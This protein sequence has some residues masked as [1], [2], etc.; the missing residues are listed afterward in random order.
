MVL[1]ATFLNCYSQV[2]PCATDF[3]HND[4][5]KNSSFYRS[6]FE[7]NESR[8]NSFIHSQKNLRVSTSSEVLYTIP[9]VVHVLEPDTSASIMTDQEIEEMISRL[10]NQLRAGEG[11][12]DSQDINI[13]FALA[14]RNPNCETTNGIVRVDMSEDLTY[15]NQGVRS[16]TDKGI[17]ELAAKSKSNWGNINYYNLWIVNKIDDQKGNG[18]IGF[19]YFPGV[20][21]DLDGALMIADRLKNENSSLLAHEIGHALGVYH[22]FNGSGGSEEE[23]YS[24]ASNQSPSTQGDRCADTEPMHFGG[25]Y[26]S[27]GLFDCSMGSDEINPC[28]GKPYG[29]LFRNFMNYV[30]DECAALF[31]ENQKDRMRATLLKARS[32]L[33]NSNALKEAPLVP[34]AAACYPTAGNKSDRFFGITSFDFDKKLVSES[35]SVSQDGYFSVDYSCYKQVEVLSDSTYPVIIKTKNSNYVKVYIDYNNDGDFEDDGEEIAS[36]L[37]YP[38]KTFSFN[39]TVP[40]SGVL[41]NQELRMRVVCDPSNELSAC[42]LPGNI[43]NG[44]GQ[45][46]DYGIKITAVPRPCLSNVV[47]REPLT[48]LGGVNLIESLDSILAGIRIIGGQTI[49]HGTDN[50]I[51]EPGF[52]VSGGAVFAAEIKACAN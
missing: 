13:E 39:Y 38:N 14:R 48:Q 33:L 30:P 51:L 37:S 10:N 3:R 43:Y 21:A 47:L 18:V 45:S 7:A 25:T 28:T 49:L 22:T 23:G 36:G 4:L 6:N 27:N 8:V 46:E 1:M 26:I 40:S 11:Y 5:L 24:C 32:T 44:S 17:S 15:I 12:Q 20:G 29:D 31:T 19:A 34:M 35:G 50:V 16:A 41:V 9:L 52:E 2:Q 42:S